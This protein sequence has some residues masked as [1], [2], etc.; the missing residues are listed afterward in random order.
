MKSLNIDWMHLPLLRTGIYA[1]MGAASVVVPDAG[2]ALLGAALLSELVTRQLRN[3]TT[4]LWEGPLFRVG[5]VADKKPRPPTS[6]PYI[7]RIW[8]K[9]GP[10]ILDRS[11]LP[12]LVSSGAC[13]VHLHKGALDRD[14]LLRAA[15]MAGR[16][17][18]VYVVDLTELTKA[19]LLDPV[20]TMALKC[21]W[22]ELAAPYAM[23][24]DMVRLMSVAKSMEEAGLVPS[25]M[26]VTEALKL[27]SMVK[28]CETNGQVAE[29]IRWGTHPLY[30]FRAERGIDQSRSFKEFHERTLG[31]IERSLAKLQEKFDPYRSND[32]DVTM[33]DVVMAGRIL[34]VRIPDDDFGT[35]LDPS[36]AIMSTLGQLLGRATVPL[37]RRTV[38]SLRDVPIDEAFA[39][40]FPM[41]GTTLL[42]AQE[43]DVK[44]KENS[45]KRHGIYKESR[46]P[47]QDVDTAIVEAGGDPKG[48]LG[49]I[50]D[51][52]L[53]KTIPEG[54]V[55][56]VRDGRIT[57]CRKLES[58][59]P[60]TAA[61][62]P[63][64]PRLLDMGALR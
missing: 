3:R 48:A 15:A 9:P 40:S 38:L 14:H 34:T 30:E 51:V 11:I 63:E 2:P 62:V 33:T 45:P 24:S 53:V 25:G 42:L 28:A 41:Y 47:L 12:D 4:T 35:M 46:I 57:I 18:D 16:Q 56:H 36:F 32:V 59:E 22:M 19:H 21:S 1:C 27:S 31:N 7:V 49:P 8:T 50:F 37:G 5:T 29:E 17:D 52:D 43:D 26:P 44:P 23:R 20:P 61:T 54:S 6:A 13:V 58:M 55:L 10:G 39:T 64:G 60:D